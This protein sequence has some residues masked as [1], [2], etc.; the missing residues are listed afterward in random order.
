MVFDEQRRLTILRGPG[1]ANAM[2]YSRL[3]AE[4]VH[5]LVWTI[6]LELAPGDHKRGDYPCRSFMIHRSYVLVCPPPVFGS[7]DAYAMA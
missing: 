6:P 3:V 4:S 2:A 7:S 5:W 1:N